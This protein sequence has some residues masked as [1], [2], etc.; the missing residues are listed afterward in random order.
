MSK[1]ILVSPRTDALHRW[2]Q[3]FPDA[4]AFAN[5]NEAADKVGADDLV[6]LHLPPLKRDARR[7]VELASARINGVRMVALADIPDDEQALELME[8]GVVGYC[9]AHAGEQMLKQVAA[10][11]D[12]QSL[13]VGPE[14]LQRL[15][16]AGAKPAA[17]AQAS[18]E[19]VSLDS[20]SPRELEVARLVADGMSNK[21]IARELDITER[22]VKA[23][24]SACFEKLSVRDR[25]HLA[26]VV[27]RG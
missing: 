1:H 15:I 12:N 13:W 24:L 18:L 4:T 23:H 20:L 16:K 2:H 11:V 21:E 9:H 7:L 10:V 27:N 6:W 22:T 25:L 14:L 5:I 19:P 26:L 17:E 3:A 8:L